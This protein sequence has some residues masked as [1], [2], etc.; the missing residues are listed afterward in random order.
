M[1]VRT[2]DHMH[3]GIYI[4]TSIFDYRLK[5]IRPLVIVHHCVDRTYALF[6]LSMDMIDILT[7][8]MNACSVG[9]V[10]FLSYKGVADMNE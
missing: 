1:Y 6:E 7:V 8:S 10:C 3:D 4:V 2:F 5:P 9:G